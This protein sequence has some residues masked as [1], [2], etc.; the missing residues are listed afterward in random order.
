MP[1]ELRVNSP[2]AFSGNAAGN[3]KGPTKR[4][5]PVPKSARAVI[6]RDLRAERAAR[7]SAAAEPLDG[8][9]ID[10]IV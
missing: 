3:E 1:D 5:K 9:H 2:T 4:R 7:D 8:R 10:V 6:V